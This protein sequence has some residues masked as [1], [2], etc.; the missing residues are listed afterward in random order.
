MTEPT[1][2]KPRDLFV[3]LVAA[4]CYAAMAGPYRTDRAA[5]DAFVD[6]ETFVAEF[7]RRYG[8]FPED[9]D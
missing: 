9:F 2:P 8:K 6:G 7:E 3:S 5:K 4:L 1:E